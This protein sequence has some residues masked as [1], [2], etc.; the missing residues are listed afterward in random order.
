MQYFYVADKNDDLSEI[1]SIEM[2]EA[3]ELL[4]DAN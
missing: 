1:E 4:L 2:T 3:E